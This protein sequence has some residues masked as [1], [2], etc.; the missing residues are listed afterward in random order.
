[1]PEIVQMWDVSSD[2]G[3]H[4]HV[5]QLEE[6]SYQCSC[7]GWTRHVPR[8]DCK[9]IQWVLM[10][11]STVHGPIKVLTVDPMLMA[12]AKAQRRAAKKGVA[13]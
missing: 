10:Y 5:S 11:G 4:Y 1:M 2:S 6:G 12:M 9:H 13:S 7:L 8:R 3:N